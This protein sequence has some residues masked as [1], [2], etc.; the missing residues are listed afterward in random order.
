MGQK[1]TNVRNDKAKRKAHEIKKVIFIRTLAN[2]LICLMNRFVANL[3]MF[4]IKKIV[5]LVKF[6]VIYS[7]TL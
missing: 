7:I 3:K 1:F 5:V 6:K 4:K 2:A